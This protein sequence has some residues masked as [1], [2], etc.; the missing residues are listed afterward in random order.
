LRVISLGA[1]TP[2]ATPYRVRVTLAETAGHAAT[3][4]AV[5]LK[6]TLRPPPEPVL[7]NGFDFGRAAWFDR[8][9]GTGYAGGKLAPLQDG[10]L[11]PLDLRLW[12]AIDRVRDAISNHIRVALPGERGEIA[13][14]HITGQR[15]GITDEVNQAMRNSGLFHILSISGLHM[16]IM[17]GTV[18]W[19]VRAFLALVPALA[20]TFPIRKWAAAAAM[21]AARGY[22]ALSG[23]AVPTVRSW[24]M[25]SIVL[26]AVLLDRP[27]LTMRNV[28]LTAL[29][30]LVLEPETVFDPSFQMSF[31]AV[32]GLVALFE[33]RP[34]RNEAFAEDVSLL[35]RLVHKLRVIVTGDALSTLVATLAVAPFAVYHFHRMSHYGVFA[36][37]LALP[38]VSLLIMPMALAALVAMPFGLETWP[39]QGMG[40]GIRS[41]RRGRRMGGVLARRGLRAPRHLR[42]C[43]GAHGARRLVALPVANALARAR[44]RH[45]RLRA[46]PHRKDH[47]ARRVD[48]A[49]RPQY[50]SAHLRRY[51][52]AAARHD[53]QLQ[54]REL[55]ARRW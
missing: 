49:R 36:N 22:L 12:A 52:C 9:G 45:C 39:L 26:L 51:A 28:A 20:L 19:L 53:H 35:W 48:R 41:A 47:A 50:R 7:P 40:L 42:E 23:A 25:M 34:R 13:A 33:S 4:D 17:A 5:T 2:E 11:A 14:A 30:I 27:A 16:V 15:A 29:L 38:L 44:P 21:A 8:L 18:F 3:G 31:A 24:A 54:H 1:L 6:A 37:L 46:R 43:A 32:I 55:A 10:G